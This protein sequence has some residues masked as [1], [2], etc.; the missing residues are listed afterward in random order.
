MP[1]LLSVGRTDQTQFNKPRFIS[2]LID[3]AD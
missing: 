1:L 3:D 2:V